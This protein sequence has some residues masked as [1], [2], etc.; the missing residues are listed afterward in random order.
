[1]SDEQPGLATFKFTEL[2][3]HTPNDNLCAAIGLIQSHILAEETELNPDVMFGWSRNDR[4][5]LETAVALLAA[6]T[7]LSENLR[8]DAV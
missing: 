5:A 2:R 4:A 8:W 1:M 6:M 7:G 3:M